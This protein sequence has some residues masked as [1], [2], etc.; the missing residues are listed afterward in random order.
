MK[1]PFIALV[2]VIAVVVVVVLFLLSNL[3][4]LVAK[5]IERGGAT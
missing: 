5:A 4:S 2:I 1:K 3:N